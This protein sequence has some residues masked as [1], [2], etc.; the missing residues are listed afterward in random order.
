M[1]IVLCSIG[2]WSAFQC[3]ELKNYLMERGIATSRSNPYHLQGNGQVEGFNGIVWKPVKSMLNTRDLSVMQWKKVLPSALHAIRS[4]LC[5]GINDT[6]HE[7]FFQIY[8]TLKIQNIFATMVVAT[9]S[10]NVAKLCSSKQIR[11]FGK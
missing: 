9:W 5:T 4:L 10:S 3:S 1:V 8:A 7:R 2:Q 11:R 6:P